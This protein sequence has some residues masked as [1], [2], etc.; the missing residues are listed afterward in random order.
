L[1][2]QAQDPFAFAVGRSLGAAVE[3]HTFPGTATCDW[4]ADMG[5]TVGTRRV[6]AAVLE[7]SGSALT[8]CMRDAAGVPLSGGPYLSEYLADTRRALAILSEAG[9]SVY[10]GG[11]PLHRDEGAQSAGSELRAMYRSQAAQTHATYI[12]AGSSVLD[13]GNYTDTLPCLTIEGP[14]QGCRGGRIAVRASD[15]VHF[16]PLVLTTANGL[17]CWCP[18]WSSG[19]VR[20]GIAMAIPVIAGLRSRGWR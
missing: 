4:L 5:R 17:A 6:T 3:A 14:D 18:V 16:C 20:F 13:H 19:A 10:L 15:G 9:V 7:F 2:W 8:P 12:D 1:A 11:S